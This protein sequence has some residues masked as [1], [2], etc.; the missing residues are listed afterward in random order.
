M[1]GIVSNPDFKR[2]KNQG[3]ETSCCVSDNGIGI[4]PQYHELIFGLFNRLDQSNEGTGVG[5]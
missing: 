1:H 4:D 2:K 5:L 3:D